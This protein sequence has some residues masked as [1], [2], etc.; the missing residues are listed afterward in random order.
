M[1]PVA[2]TSS[3]FDECSGSTPGETV[4]Y[5]SLVR[6]LVGD[7]A[8]PKSVEDSLPTI[9]VC[10]YECGAITGSGSFAEVGPSTVTEAILAPPW[11]ELRLTSEVYGMFS[12]TTYSKVA[13]DTSNSDGE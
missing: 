7:G 3:V 5:D 8:A 4:A 12:R 11:S 13:T 9:S 1:Y 6:A 2:A 10:L